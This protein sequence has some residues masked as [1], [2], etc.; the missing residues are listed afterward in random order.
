MAYSTD[1]IN[2]ALLADPEFQKADEATQREWAMNA[3]KN[4]GFMADGSP[5]VGGGV[6]RPLSAKEQV[7]GA[8]RMVL[9]GVPAA[10]AGMLVPPPMNIPAA[11]LAF[12][13]GAQAADMLDVE[14]LH[15]LRALVRVELVKDSGDVRRVQRAQALG[16]DL[17][18]EP[19]DAALERLDVVPR[20]NLRTRPDFEQ[21]AERVGDVH[22]AHAAQ[23][24]AHAGVDPDQI[25]PVARRLDA[26]IVHTHDTIVVHV[27]DLLVHHVRLEEQVFLGKAVVF[28]LIDG[29][30]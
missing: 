24:A 28:D 19:A 8:A 26:N 23:Q 4:A 7:S 11:V 1:E 14:R 9:E 21:L 17:E 3:Y 30:G 20:D 18:L 5:V 6:N 27:H 10:A 16:G 29:N 22:E 25:Q 13:A 2:A 15:D 12:A